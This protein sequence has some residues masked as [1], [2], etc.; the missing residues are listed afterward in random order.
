MARPRFATF[1]PSPP[2]GEFVNLIE[3]IVLLAFPGI[4]QVAK[5]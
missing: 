1:I 3:D 5:K 2:D 4:Y